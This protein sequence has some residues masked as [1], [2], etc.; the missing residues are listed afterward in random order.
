MT[1]VLLDRL[2]L[3]A[4]M[5]CLLMLAL[6]YWWLDNLPHEMF[7]TAMFALLIRHFVANRAWFRNLGRGRL[8]ARRIAVLL[9][10]MVL[11]VNMIVLLVTSLMISRTVLAFLPFPDIPYLREVHWFSAYWVVV[12]V[13]LHVGMHWRRLVALVATTLGLGLSRRAEIALRV[14]AALIVVYGA[15]SF[16][17]LGVWTKLTFTYSLEFWDFTSSVSPFFAHW[18]GVIALFAFVGHFG[19]LALTRPA[20]APATAQIHGRKGVQ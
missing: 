4:A 8:D 18:A 11:T 10:H 7:G 14:L 17:I 19:A 12:I 3:P 6:A 20:R 5:A 13:G 1:R 9:L 16:V 15:W 2:A